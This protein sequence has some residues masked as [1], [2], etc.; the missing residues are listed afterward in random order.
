M[1]MEVEIWLSDHSD[2]DHSCRKK[3]ENEPDQMQLILRLQSKRGFSLHTILCSPPLRPPPPPPPP[4]PSLFLFLFLLL[5]LIPRA[6]LS[7]RWPPSSSLLI[8]FSPTQN[9]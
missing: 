6:R 5:F 7:L 3:I 9:Q 2:R 8:H 1:G 4:P